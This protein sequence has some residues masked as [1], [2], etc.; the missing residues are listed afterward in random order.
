MRELH[1]AGELQPLIDRLLSAEL[2]LPKLAALAGALLLAYALYRYL[3]PAGRPTYLVDF[4]VHKVRA[5]LCHCV[6]VAGGAAAGVCAVPL[7]LPRGAPHL[8]RRFLRA[9][10]DRLQMSADMCK[11]KQAALRTV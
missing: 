1:T 7:P 6:L 4:S 3:F 11:A 5:G 8:L 10:G 9:Q 2:A